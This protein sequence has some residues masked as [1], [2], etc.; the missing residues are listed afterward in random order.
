VC[1]NTNFDEDAKPTMC[2]GPWRI[3]T[4]LCDGLYLFRCKTCGDERLMVSENCPA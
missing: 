4:A 1:P 2:S 3:V